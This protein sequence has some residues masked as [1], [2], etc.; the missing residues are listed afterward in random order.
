VTWWLIPLLATLAA[1][2][3]TRVAG[4]GRAR[5]RPRPEPGSEADRRDLARF[6]EALA[7]PLPGH[8][9]G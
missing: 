8:V 6:A 3:Y 1:W 9:D 2:A 7:R 5:L 4:V